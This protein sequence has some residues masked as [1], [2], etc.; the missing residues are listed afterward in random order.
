M[1]LEKKKFDL[2]IYVL[3]KS[4]EP[5]E[6]YICNEGLVR[7]STEGYSKPM[8]GNKKNM[9]VHLTNSTLHKKKDDYMNEEEEMDEVHGPKRL[10]TKVYE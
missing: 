6:A 7:I 1:L 3:V 10:L 5:V 8:A 2:R 9:F 4:F